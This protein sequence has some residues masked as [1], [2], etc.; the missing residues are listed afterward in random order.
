MAVGVYLRVSTE[1]QREQQS[2]ATQREFAERYCTLHGLTVSCTYAD[3]GIS[4]TTPLEQRPDGSQILNDAAARKFDQLLVYKLDRLG[5]ETRLILN[6]VA[7][8]EKLG[9]RIRSMTEEFDTGTPA[10]RLMLTL[11]SGF[12][13]HEREVIRERSVAG[14]NRVAESGAWMGGIVPYGY[15]RVGEKREARIVISDDAI[16]KLEMSESEV[17][18][19]VFRMAA[20]EGKSCRVI[21]D[22]LNQLR[23]PCA[24]TRDDRLHLHG[25]R[26]QRTSG[27]WRPG[28]IRWLIT[29]STYK[30]IHQFG[31]RSAGKR[32]IISRPVPAIVS[33]D[34]WAKA[35]KTLHGNFLFSVRGAKNQY[36][37][38]GL[39]KCALCGHT[40]TGVNTQRPNGTREFYYRCNLA[41]TP[42]IHGA[43]QRCSAKGVRGDE[44]EN[45]IWADVENFLRNP[46]GVLQQL[47]DRMAAES[48]GAD[49][50]R[51]QV[52]RL[53]G[54]LAQK[55]TER[56]RILG[57]YRRGRLTDVDLDTQMDEIGREQAALEARLGELRAKL[58]GSGSTALKSAESLL[59]ALR[60]RLDE[61]VSWELK[62]RLVEILVAGIRVET[63]E[64]HGVKQ[65]RIITTYRFAEPSQPMP[66]VL[67]QSYITGKVVRI[68]VEPKTIGITSAGGGWS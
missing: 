17:V 28:R 2:I 56:S 13:S 34:V 30:G 51:K 38:R 24:Y 9:V 68:P 7:E 8:L 60:K 63:I 18:R 3:E 20:I 65:A 45:Q 33:E 14:T 52:A 27:L 12:A 44:F 15:R 55:V 50:I 48:K 64:V 66:L 42:G 39:I 26:K 59:K 40:Y 35:Q 22:R 21:A 36:L 25:K 16:Q 31:K 54:L 5:R 53:E 57:L 49:Q 43:T 58:S 1:E 61:P 41:N 67:A 19:E 11:L 23:V 29:N 62:R 32:E 46:E 4:G 47:Q 37:L 10:G 6:T